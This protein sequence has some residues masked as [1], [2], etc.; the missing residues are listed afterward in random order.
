MLGGDDVERGDID[1]RGIVSAGREV[2]TSTA[3]DGSAAASSGR[4]SERPP[5]ER[6][7]CC[8]CSCSFATGYVASEADRRLKMKLSSCEKKI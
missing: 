8:V 2:S 1:W 4:Y 7:H 5:R 3:G 6:P